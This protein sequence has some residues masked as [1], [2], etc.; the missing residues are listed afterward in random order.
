MNATVGGGGGLQI[1]LH[2]GSTTAKTR[3]FWFASKN[4]RQNVLARQRLK[5]RGL[6]N[7]SSPKRTFGFSAKA[8][9]LIARH[10][11]DQKEGEEKEERTFLWGDGRYHP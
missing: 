6:T 9:L 4:L 8:T 2:K 11:L 1:K 5:K 3:P 7:T 10:Q